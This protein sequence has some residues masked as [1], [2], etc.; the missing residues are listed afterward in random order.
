MATTEGGIIDLCLF[1]AAATPRSNFAL[2]NLRALCEQYLAGHYR[3]EVV[4]LVSDPGQ[5]R[6]NDVVAIPTLLKRG[7]GPPRRVIGDLTDPL[8]VLRGLDLG[9]FV[10]PTA[11]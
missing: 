3:I 6:L 1:V 2:S 9:P 7:P 11:A 10:P 5:A 8:A 4:D